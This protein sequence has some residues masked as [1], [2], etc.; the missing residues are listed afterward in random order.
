MLVPTDR[1]SLTCDCESTGIIGAL[2][3]GEL[4]PGFQVCKAVI[5]DAISARS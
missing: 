3:D 4:F 1:F 5:S 2:L